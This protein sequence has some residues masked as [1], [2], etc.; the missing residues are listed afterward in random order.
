[1]K[2]H[3]I[4]TAAAL[5]F[6]G[7]ATTKPRNSERVP[8]PD[9]SIVQMPID[10]AKVAS[11]KATEKVGSARATVQATSAKVRQLEQS[12]AVQEIQRDLDTVETELADAQGQLGQTATA[13]VEA[14]NRAVD[15]QGQVNG[16]ALKYSDAKR[17]LSNAEDALRTEKAA[18]KQTSTAYHRLK[19]FVAIVLAIIAGL[20]ATR[21]VPPGNLW[22]Q[23]GAPLA[24]AAIVFLTA[25]NFL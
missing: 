2:A 4:I 18:H 24:V 15:L 25:W 22:W 5:I 19:F 23:I 9:V 16:L 1:M 14:T 21:F 13:L 17:D 6:A 3:L 20:I 7:C 10:R 12:T 11:T 8:T